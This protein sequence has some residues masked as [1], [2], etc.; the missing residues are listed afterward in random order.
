MRFDTAVH[1]V[2]T[3]IAIRVSKVPEPSV[4]VAIEHDVRAALQHRP[5]ER[6]RTRSVPVHLGDTVRVLEWIDIFD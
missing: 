1:L 3:G 6:R 4:L 5:S 2:S